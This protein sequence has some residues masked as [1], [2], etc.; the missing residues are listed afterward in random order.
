[1]EKHGWRVGEN[2]SAKYVGDLEKHVRRFGETCSAKVLEIWR[3]VFGDLEKL[4]VTPGFK[5]KTRYTLYV[6]PGSQ[7]S[8]IATNKGNIKR[9][10][11]VLTPIPLRLSLGRPESMGPVH[12]KDD[13]RPSQPGWSPAQGVKVDLAIKQDPGRLE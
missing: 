13:A 4:V 9:H 6:S 11:G 3:N 7:I 10:V 2:C 1:M 8:H 5:D 12:P